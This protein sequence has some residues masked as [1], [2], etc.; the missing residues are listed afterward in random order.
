MVQTSLYNRLW[1]SAAVAREIQGIQTI[2]DD[3]RTYTLIEYQEFRRTTSLS[4]GVS[5]T[6]GLSRLE[7]EDGRAV[8]QRDSDTFEVVESGQ[9]LRK[10]E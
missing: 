6:R 3:G 8:N 9:V 2:G 5:M 1:G 10:A 4:D 7:L